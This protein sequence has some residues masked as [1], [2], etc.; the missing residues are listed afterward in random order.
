MSYAYINNARYQVLRAAFVLCA[1]YIVY[2]SI[3]MTRRGGGHR[4]E[5]LMSFQL[6]PRTPQWSAKQKLYG[7]RSERGEKTFVVLICIYINIPLCTC[8][9]VYVYVCLC[10]SVLCTNTMQQQQFHLI[11]CIVIITYIYR[12]D[13]PLA[14]AERIMSNCYRE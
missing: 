14:Y 2:Y 10:V 3:Y 6:G 5:I 8:V 1:I 12:Y 4:C 9:C 11:V 7:L 13:L